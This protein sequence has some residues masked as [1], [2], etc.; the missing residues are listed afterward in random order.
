MTTLVSIPKSLAGAIN[1]AGHVRL[2]SPTIVLF[3]RVLRVTTSK[4]THAHVQPQRRAFVMFQDGYQLDITPWGLR[5]T[6]IRARVESV[7]LFAGRAVGVWDLP[8]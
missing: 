6:L 2:A 3:P 5:G 1:L 8:S 7:L 4:A